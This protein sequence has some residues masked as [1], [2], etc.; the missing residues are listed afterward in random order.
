MNQ[1]AKDIK[2]YL[3]ELFPDA[4]CELK[5]NNAFELLIAVSLSAQTT[6]IA[7]NKVSPNLFKLYPDPNSLAKANLNDVKNC[8]KTIGLYQNKSKNIIE[9][10]KQLVSD[11]D[12]KVP[13]SR[14]E[15]IKLK[16][17]GR[18]TANVVLAEYFKYPAIAVD[19]HVHRISQRLRI[20]KKDED[21]YVNELKLMKL[22]PKYLWHQ[23]H[24]QLIFFGRYKCKAIK[25]D[26]SACKLIKYCN[27]KG[28]D[29]KIDK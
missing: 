20:I 1:K 7:V 9:L 5:Y 11:Y 26:C 27:Y 13:F 14:E 21:V 3:D 22:F 28:K 10:A 2:N 23:I 16:G 19:T 4:H 6:D 25:P 8:L 24:H 18:K 17:V 29:H 15:L 12:S